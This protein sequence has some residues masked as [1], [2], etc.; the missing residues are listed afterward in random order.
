MVGQCLCLDHKFHLE[1][2]GN[3]ENNGEKKDWDQ[4]GGD[5]S[6][7]VGS[8]APVVVL[9]GTPNGSVSLQCQGQGDVNRTAVVQ[10]QDFKF[11]C[12]VFA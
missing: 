4:V 1:K 6:P 5:S 9:D 8:F 10:R 2:L 12:T 7:R 11:K 3:V